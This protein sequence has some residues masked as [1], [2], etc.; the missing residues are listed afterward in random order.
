M[1]IDR[2]VRTSKGQVIGHVAER[3][4]QGIDAS[5]LVGIGP[6]FPRPEANS[7]PPLPLMWLLA[8]TA[9]EPITVIPSSAPAALSW[10][11]CDQ[12]PSQASL[13]SSDKYALPPADGLHS[14]PRATNEALSGVSVD[15]KGIV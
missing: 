13:L 4:R 11:I 6:P 5:S 15:R 7:S 2:P 14:L 10:V 3:P 1:A 9:H 12:M 8:C